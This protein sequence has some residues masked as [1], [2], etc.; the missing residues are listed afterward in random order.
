MW[1][2]SDRTVNDGASGSTS[3]NKV[4]LVGRILLN[5]RIVGRYE[6]QEPCCTTV[7]QRVFVNQVGNRPSFAFD[8]YL[9][10]L[11][12]RGTFVALVNT[13]PQFAAKSDD[14]NRTH[15][16]STKQPHAAVAKQKHINHAWACHRQAEAGDCKRR[17]PQLWFVC[18]QCRL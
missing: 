4:W 18:G 10:L 1:T 2:A 9:F 11:L 13:L 5:R 12:C 8:L 6:A 3:P 7:T 15:Q 17:Q 16:Q 14:F